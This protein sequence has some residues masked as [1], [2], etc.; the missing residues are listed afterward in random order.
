[1]DQS[2]P[3]APATIEDR[4]AITDI[5]HHYIRTSHATFELEPRTEEVVRA[6]FEGF[7]ER[8][9]NRLLVAREGERVL[10]Y[11]SSSMFR[12]RAAY[13]P[14]VETSVYLDPGSTGRGVGTALLR[15]L[16]SELG[17]EDVHRACAGIA[18]PNPASVRLHQRFGYRHVGTFTEQ[19]YKFGRF[20]DVAWFERAFP[21]QTAE[22]AS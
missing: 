15:A 4:G 20:W 11:A 19:G 5:Y 13:A 9:R 14:T 17:T 22:E 2:L 18:L 1:M 3:I 6:W 12:P 7:G 10:G 8:G 21:S 16:L